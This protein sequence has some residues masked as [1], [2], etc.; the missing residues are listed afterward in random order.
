MAR[1][2][3]TFLF[4]LLPVHHKFKVAKSL[5]GT[6]RTP[7]KADGV[8]SNFLIV[9]RL[10]NDMLRAPIASDSLLLQRIT[11]RSVR[12][13]TPL[14]T[15]LAIVFVVKIVA[16][17]TVSS[18]SNQVITPRSRGKSAPRVASL[19]IFLIMRTT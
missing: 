4:R 13:L 6:V 3:G 14:V 8:S 17:S 15:A 9:D 11:L 12:A 19:T 5:L 16:P 18:F 10:G 7:P 2:S 1:I